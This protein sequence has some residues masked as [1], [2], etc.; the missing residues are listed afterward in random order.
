MLRQTSYIADIV[1]E[2][3][4]NIGNY[5]ISDKNVTNV[6]FSKE[7]DRINEY[8]VVEFMKDIQVTYPFIYSIGIY[9]ENIDR[10]INTKGYKR[11]DEADLIDGIIN[12]NKQ[13]YV[14]FFPRKAKNVVSDKEINLL[15]FVLYP[16]YSSYLPKKGAIII[17]FEEQYLQNL[18]GHLKSESSNT[19]VVVDE[20]GNILSESG[21][22]NFL[23]NIGSEPY[24]K[25]VLNNENLSGNF[26]TD[27]NKQRSLVSFKKSDGLGWYL[28]GI[29][30]YSDL[31][32]AE[33]N[34]K[35]SIFVI[36][37]CLFLL[38]IVGSIFL[39]NMLYKPINML[40]DKIAVRK[41]DAFK[42][43]EFQLLDHKFSQL[44][45]RLKFLEPAMSVI[46]KSYLLHYINGSKV[47][48][49]SRYHHP[50]QGNYYMVVIL[51]METLKEDKEKFNSQIH[52]LIQF[53]ICNLAM[54]IVGKEENI[55]T[56]IIEED[57]IGI[58]VLLDAEQYSDE[59]I[60]SLKDLQHY[61]RDYMDISFTAGVGNVIKDT[62]KI[63]ESYLKAKLALNE[64]FTN[65]GGN[66]FVYSDMENDI[67][68]MVPGLQN[69]VDI[70]LINAINTG[71][72]Q[73][74]INEINA[75][76][77][78][79]VGTKY[80]EAIFLLKTLL[81]SLYKHYENLEYTKDLAGFFTDLIFQLTQIETLQEVTEKIEE[82]CL[83]ICNELGE[84]SKNNNNE[85]IESIQEYVK[86]NY[87]D[88]NLSIDQLADQVQLTPG[89]L[90]KMFK[91][92]CDMSFNDYLKNIRLEKA[93]NLLL[94]TN[95]A[96]N[97]ISEKIG[98]P[99]TT[100]FYT[101]FKKKFGL[102]PAKY[103]I[104]NNQFKISNE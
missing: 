40:M 55:E 79:L 75:F 73:E 44:S 46:E 92:H 26:T 72:R 25:K 22:G 94:E 27:I 87:A 36:A 101:L 28:I 15:T 41:K 100:Y 32:F 96:A 2:Q 90:G 48:L 33:K 4:F 7:I 66:I 64:R 3:V 61:V 76:R 13:M 95:Q 47:D 57:E 5:L 42:I 52:S 83:S 17:N 16:G 91:T 59:L 77:E 78:M 80:Q 68:N 11:Q 51:K 20:K 6:M 62:K 43:N 50:L 84:R 35:K 45:N 24:V 104:A 89:Y 37:F 70:K 34:L 56:V 19:L 99:N 23:E 8:N 103:R 18:V 81:F 69:E 39:T 54:E 10:Y 74:I 30:H 53:S 58:F 65:G 29:N 88:P 67:E 86:K 60:P 98:I 9:N 63:R 1:N 97:V 82:I 12:Q 49:E 31:L 71:N 38:C 93:R 102:S 21:G 85:I 14:S